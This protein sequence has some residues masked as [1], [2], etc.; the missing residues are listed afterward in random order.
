MD[1]ETLLKTFKPS[2]MVLLKPEKDLLTS[3]G[4]KWCRKC[5]S[6]KELSCF[7]KDSHKKDGLTAKCLC[8]NRESCKTY[9]ANNGEKIYTRKKAYIESNPELAISIRKKSYLKHRKQRVL[10][11]ISHNQNRYKTDSNFKTI[12]ICRHLVHRAFNT[13][14]TKKEEKTIDFLGYSAKDLKEHLERQFRDGMDW[15]N[16]GEW[17]ID[18]IVPI[19]LATNIE[20]A[21]VLSQLSNLQPLWKAENLLKSNK[22]DYKIE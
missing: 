7:G 20:Q 12:T 14:G 2:G 4:L 10:D 21:R 19:S 18:H 13:I 6:V 16:H 22:L 17:C 9:N 5:E 3:F 8:C 11:S 15:S 1:K